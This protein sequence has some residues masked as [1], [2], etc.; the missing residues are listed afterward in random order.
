[1]PQIVHEIRLAGPWEQRSNDADDWQR[2]R[3][4]YQIDAATSDHCLR[5]K[6][7]RPSGLEAA[8]RLVLALY[9]DIS[10]QEVVINQAVIE[11]TEQQDG[12]SN[13]AIYLFDITA[14]AADF[15]TLEVRVSQPDD[16][17]SHSLHEARLQIVE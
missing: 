13:P 16:G 6:F 17:K 11:L 9:A 7:H 14:A 4:P 2:T 10:L 5:R 12:A 1:M 8:S 15:N 3:L